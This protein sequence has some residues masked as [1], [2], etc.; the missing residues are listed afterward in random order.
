MTAARMDW[1][2]TSLATAQVY[3]FHTTL[4]SSMHCW[5]RTHFQQSN[6]VLQIPDRE[7]DAHRHPFG[8]T[9][10]SRLGFAVPSKAAPSVSNS[11]QPE[12]T[13][14]KRQHFS[15]I[16]FRIVRGVLPSPFKYLQA[17]PRYKLR[18]KDSRAKS[19]SNSGLCSLISQR[20][21]HY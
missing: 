3:Y 5:L 14:G 18:L 17:Y 15:F 11:N 13:F 16:Y 6:Q 1:V 12:N 10:L 9:L 19:F 21:P 20:T 4:K 2:E 8:N 7:C